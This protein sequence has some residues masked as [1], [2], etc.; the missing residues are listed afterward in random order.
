[1]GISKFSKIKKQGCYMDNKTIQSFN[2]QNKT[3]NILQGNENLRFR[4]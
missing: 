2:S 4:A 1:M 3:T